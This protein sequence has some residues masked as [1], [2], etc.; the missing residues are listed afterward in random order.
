MLKLA[1]RLSSINLQLARSCYSFLVS[2]FLILNDIIWV[3]KLLKTHSG[4]KQLFEINITL[5]RIPTGRRQNSWLFTSMVEKKNKDL[6]RTNPAINIRAGV[7][8]M[9]S[10]LL[11]QCSNHSATLLA[12]S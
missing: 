11:L 10:R 7:E 6:P 1:S 2:I 4:L 3:A 8:L 5:I 9:A 12:F